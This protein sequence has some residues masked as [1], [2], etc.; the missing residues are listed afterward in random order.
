MIFPLNGN[1]NGQCSLRNQ[2]EMYIENQRIVGNELHFCGRVITWSPDVY[3]MVVPLG[4]HC[5]LFRPTACC[6][7]EN[8]SHRSD[9]GVVMLLPVYRNNNNRAEFKQRRINH[10]DRLQIVSKD[11][12]IFPW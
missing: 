10:I 6:G 4:S 8:K 12:S 1:S 9:L 2:V 5:K 3:T 11:D 7:V